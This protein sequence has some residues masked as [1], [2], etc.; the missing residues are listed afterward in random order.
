MNVLS[1]VLDTIYY[2]YVYYRKTRPLPRRL[3]PDLVERLLVALASER[4]TSAVPKPELATKVESEAES[5][6]ELKADADAA[7]CSW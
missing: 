4:A 5:E 3:Q 6:A 1:I 7:P 2:S